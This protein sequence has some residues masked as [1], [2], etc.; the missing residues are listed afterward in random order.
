M[1]DRFPNRHTAFGLGAHRCLGSHFARAEIVAMVGAVLARM[2][3]FE[4][5]EET[6]EQYTTIG[7]VNGW[8]TM[9]ARFTPGARRGA[10]AL[11]GISPR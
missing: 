11:P 4:V 5:V 6:A 8:I 1:I 7:I 2:P 3:D 9:P 10:E